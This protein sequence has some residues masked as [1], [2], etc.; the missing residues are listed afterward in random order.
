MRTDLFWC[1]YRFTACA[2]DIS[3]AVPCVSCD[4]CEKGVTCA[5]RRCPKSG[6]SL[7]STVSEARHSSAYPAGGHVQGR[8][9]TWQL[10]DG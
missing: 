1:A 7:V 4:D 9:D 2:S 6:S 5:E 10:A 3:S 8:R